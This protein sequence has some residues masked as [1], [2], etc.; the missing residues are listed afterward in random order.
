MTGPSF[1]ARRSALSA[2]PRIA[3]LTVAI[4]LLSFAFFAFFACVP[5]EGAMDIREAYSEIASA[6]DFKAKECGH[7]PSY[8][9]VLP[10]RPSKYGIRLCSISIVRQECPFTAYPVFCLEVYTVV[11][12]KEL[13]NVCDLPFIGP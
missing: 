1:H 8:P 11:C 13:K 2:A 5:E 6:I 10:D 4:A 3:S 9:L 12:P 7:R